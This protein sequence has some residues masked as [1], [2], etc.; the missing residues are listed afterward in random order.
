[1]LS[2]ALF[3]ALLLAVLTPLPVLAQGLRFNRDIR[4]IL[5]EHCFACHGF[6][7]NKRDS[8]LRLDRREDALRPARSGAIPIVPGKPEESELIAR[9]YSTEPDDLMPP[10]KA[11][12][13]LS[14]AQRELLKR[15]VAEGAPYEPHWAYAPLAR[16]A[17]GAEGS[18]AIDWFVEQRLRAEGIEASPTADPETLRRRIALDLV[19][20]PPVAVQGQSGESP[21]PDSA[22]GLREWIEQLLH[23]PRYGERWA[24]WWLDAVRFADTVGYHGDQTQR[25]FPYRDYV[26]EAF[27]RN[28]R[29]DEFTVEQIAGDLLPNATPEQR[30]ASGFNRLSMMT[31]EGGIQP[32]EYFAKYMADR[33]RAV[34]SAWLGATIGCAECHDHKFDP[35][36]QRDFYALGAYFAD[37]KQYA[38]Y[39]G[40]FLPNPDLKGWTD[41]H[42]FPPEIEVQSAYRERRRRRFEAERE[43]IARNAWEKVAAAERLSW[44]TAMRGFL[45]THPSGWM[46]PEAEPRLGAAPQGKD[47]APLVRREPDGSLFLE[48][49]AQGSLTVHLREVRGTVA[50]LRVELLPH[51]AHGGRLVRTGELEKL[52]VLPALHVRRKGANAREALPFR[53]GDARTKDP[54]Y[55]Q[56]DHEPGVLKGWKPAAA[57]PMGLQ[58]QAAVWLLRNPV[59]L[60]DGDELVCTFADGKWNA[61]CVRISVSPLATLQDGGEAFDAAGLDAPD[62][63]FASNPAEEKV[64]E[65]FVRAEQ[66]ML[67]CRNGRA[68]SL[69]SQ[70]VE[71][72]PVRVLPRGNWQDESGPLVEPATPGFLP[73]SLAGEPRRQNRLDLARWLVSAEN[74]VPPRALMNRLWKAFFGTGLSAT[75]DDL[76]TQGEPPSHPELLDWL[77]AEFRESGW[78]FRHMVRLIVNSK[79]YQRSARQRPELAGIDPSNRLLACQNPRRLEAEFV[80]DNALAIAGLLD[81]E[82][83]GPSVHI[84]F[85]KDLYRDMEFPKRVFH[86]VEDERQWRRGLYVHWQRTFLHPMLAAFDAPNRDESACM[87]TQANTPQQA[88]TLL[89]DPTFVEA[90]RMLAGKCLAACPTATDDARLEWMIRRT[91]GRGSKGAERSG[92]GKLLHEHRERFAGDA[93]GAGAL[94]RTG[95]APSAAACGVMA[96]EPEV[97]AWTSVARVLLNLHETIT[98]Y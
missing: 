49:A 86:P 13:T 98:R 71:P 84:Y 90:A 4:P 95:S 34:G 28:K 44:K 32:R 69:V 16:P 54:T 48:K 96:P 88:L 23:S 51:A 64:R 53:H 79:T 9:I 14:T 58:A 72:A 1:M 80:R 11:H 81:S 36:T 65:S 31:R 40:V 5:S 41:H 47:A 55:F 63:W 45:D 73:A 50:A 94:L 30:V 92:L 33:V 87:R 35:I 67:E 57:P 89:N 93:D 12:K 37:L 26:I 7:R 61:G 21:G 59:A 22:G 66:A 52:V 3:H 78:D 29:F 27:N 70:A 25:V 39:H 24:V 46:T 6:D 74:P 2:R 38:L 83:G 20:L 60:E 8:G 19:G 77:A 10:P 62:L 76:G 75:L 56:G 82:V 42:P 18:A 85:P 15:W 68:F 17:A 97:A 43:S 91:L